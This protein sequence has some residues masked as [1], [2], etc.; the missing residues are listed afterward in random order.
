MAEYGDQVDG[1]ELSAILDEN[2]CEVCEKLDGQEF[3]FGSAGYEENT[4]P[5]RDCEGKANCRCLYVVLFKER[6]FHRVEDDAA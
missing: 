3:D 2:T 5:V 1:V 4:P 6:G